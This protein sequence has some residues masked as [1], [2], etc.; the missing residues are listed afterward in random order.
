MSFWEF[1]WNANNS[2]ITSFGWVMTLI[3][4]LSL[5]VVI[6][7]TII[8]H[9]AKKFVVPKINEL[10]EKIEDHSGRIRNLEESNNIH[11]INYK[12]LKENLD[13]QVRVSEQ[14]ITA[15][16]RIVANME[17]TCF[18][19]Q[20][21]VEV[22]NNKVIFLTHELE[23]LQSEHSIRHSGEILKVIKPRKTT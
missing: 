14:M 13:K 16:E 12:S 10:F 9:L 1:F 3:T 20:E 11:D 22:L 2:G 17:M 23:K 4:I 21:I 6:S 5:V 15:S 7:G 18:K 19:W 8:W